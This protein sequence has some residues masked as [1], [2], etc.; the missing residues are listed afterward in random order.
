MVTVH[1]Y[2]SPAQAEFFESMDLHWMVENN[3]PVQVRRFIHEAEDF[4]VFSP[5][6]IKEKST[7]RHTWRVSFSF[8][9]HGLFLARNKVRRGWPDGTGRQ[10]TS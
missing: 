9:T 6:C 10:E 8:C 3:H 1:G 4:V 5:F 7:F 2:A